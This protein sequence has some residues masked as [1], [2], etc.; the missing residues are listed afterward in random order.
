M[1][2][3]QYNVFYHMLA[4]R[5]PKRVNINVIISEYSSGSF[6]VGLLS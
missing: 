3:S 5:S 6:S 4:Y 1:A 2:L